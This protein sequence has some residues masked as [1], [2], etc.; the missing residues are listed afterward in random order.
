[1]S[2]I[3]DDKQQPPIYN[4][5][6]DVQESVERLECQACNKVFAN[7]YSLNRHMENTQVCYKWMLLSNTDTNKNN[8]GI[9]SDIKLQTTEANIL[10]I[11]DTLRNNI[12]TCKDNTLQCQYCNKQF[13][14]IGNLNKHFRVSVACNKLAIYGLVTIFNQMEI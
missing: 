4:F 3:Y 6:L 7:K 14:N 13:S 9:T 12:L 11:L 1:M 2:D 10:D 8:T 5:D